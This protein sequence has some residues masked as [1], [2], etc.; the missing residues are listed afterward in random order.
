MNVEGG[1]KVVAVENLPTEE[2]PK[3]TTH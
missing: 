2:P 1:E 3:E